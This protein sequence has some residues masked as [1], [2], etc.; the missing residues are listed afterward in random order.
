MREDDGNRIFQAQLGLSGNFGITSTTLKKCIYTRAQQRGKEA[1]ELNQVHNSKDLVSRMANVEAKS[2]KQD[3]EI[4]VLMK[5]LDEEKKFTKKL[6][7][8]ISQLESSVRG[9]R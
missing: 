3:V 8:R 7:C 2:K 5:Q 6:N 4:I 1:I 9:L